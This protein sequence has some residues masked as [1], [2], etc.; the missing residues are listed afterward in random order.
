LTQT[1]LPNGTRQDRRYDELNRLTFLEDVGPAG[2]IASTT[3]TLGATGRRDAVRDH[4]G[5]RVDYSYDALD[6]L[7]LEQI[8]DAI[9]GDR[10][11]D[12]MYDAVGNRLSRND[13]APGS[14]LALYS[15]DANDRLLTETV[16]GQLAQYTYDNNGNT[17][18]RTSAADRL[19]YNWDFDNRLASAD[20]DGNGTADVRNVY[21]ADGNRVAQSIGTQETRLLIDTVQRRG[22]ARIPPRRPNRGRV[23][24]R[25]WPDQPGQCRRG[26]VLPRRWPGEHV[27]V[28]GRYGRCDGSVLV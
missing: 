26:I 10:T 1:Q 7:T 23:R 28:D 14:G 24:P 8:T 12:Y 27:R 2:V 15:Y 16:A 21:D 3:Y 17:L 22:S 20:T 25:P 6:R 18:S 9:L 19:L 11:I 4:T 5:R 13:S